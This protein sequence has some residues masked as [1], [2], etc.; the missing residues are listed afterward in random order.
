MQCGGRLLRPRRCPFGR[1]L[2]RCRADRG[3]ELVLAGGVPSTWPGRCTYAGSA[4]AIAYLYSAFG[5]GLEECSVLARCKFSHPAHR[6]SAVPPSV[7]TAF[8]V[9]SYHLISPNP[10]EHGPLLTPF[11]DRCATA[12]WARLS[13]CRSTTRV[14][15][16]RARCTTRTTPPIARATRAPRTLTA[17]RPQPPQPPRPR[18]AQA[19]APTARA[20]V[21]AARR[22]GGVGLRKP[23]AAAVATARGSQVRLWT[24]ARPRWWATWS[25]GS[26]TGTPRLSRHRWATAA[27]S[28]PTKMPCAT[29]CT[30]Y[31]IAAYGNVLA[32]SDK[33]IHSSYLRQPQGTSQAAPLSTCLL[34]CTPTSS[35]PQV[36]H[37]GCLRLHRPR[38]RPGHLPKPPHHRRPGGR[39]HPGC[40]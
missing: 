22:P 26:A 1:G 8:Q 38:L 25:H 14:R 20:Q 7:D 37:R 39:R 31:A 3:G 30:V 33:Y 40:R 24:L 17:G 10:Y 11:P 36:P 6:R 27:M 18:P 12:P 9:G 32:T 4:R 35:D 23:T 34:A 19:L 29:G 28:F 2:R 21:P 15:H 16:A 5:A 13:P